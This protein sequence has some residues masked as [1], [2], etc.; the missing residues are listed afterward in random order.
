MNRWIPRGLP[1]LVLGSALAACSTN[2]V[3]GEKELMLVG[4]GTELSL[5]PPRESLWSV[6]VG[7]SGAGQP[8]MPSSP[9]WGPVVDAIPTLER[10]QSVLYALGLRKDC[11]SPAGA[12]EHAS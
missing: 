6:L 2:P 12:A 11:D 1:A 10:A 9:A 3:T 7:G 4:E 5:W 8:P